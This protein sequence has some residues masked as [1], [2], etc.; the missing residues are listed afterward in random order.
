[1][2]SR[3]HVKRR[4]LVTLKQCPLCKMQ[5]PVPIAAKGGLHLETH[6]RDGHAFS[7]EDWID[8]CRWN[9]L[10][11]NSGKRGS[12]SPAASWQGFYRALFRVRD[13]ETVPGPCK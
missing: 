1:M 11:P 2:E 12:L 3:E 13:E 10:A 4:H 5:M 7:S 9:D 6:C 8:S